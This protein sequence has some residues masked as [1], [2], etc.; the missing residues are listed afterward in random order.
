MARRKTTK[1]LTKAQRSFYIL[2]N[3]NTEVYLDTA[4]CL[5]AV[6]RKLFRQGYCYGIES[7][8]FDFTGADPSAVDQVQLTAKTAADDWVT[9][10]AFVKGHALFNEMN[11]L[12]LKDN[13]SI[14]SKWADYKVFLDSNHRSTYF[15]S[16]NAQPL[17][18][19]GVAYGMGEWNYSDYV[20]PQHTVNV[21]TGAPLPAD[22]T[23]AHLIGPD[24]G[25][26][27]AGNLQSVGLIQAY[28]DSRATVF[29]DAPN[30]P[31]GFADSFFNVLTDSGSQEP[32]LAGVIRAENDN[33]PYDLNNYPGGSTNAPV[34]VGADF[35]TA[36]IG[37][38]NAVVG[39]FVAPC[40][41][42]RLNLQS[43]FQGAQAASFPVLMRVT[44]MAGKYK[45]I[46]AI[47]MGQ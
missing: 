15:A 47:P 27:A 40:G 38:P 1:A 29:P 14:Q 33:P 3:T 45:G 6:N 20:L 31:A 43:Y 36:T 13:P 8:E 32:E 35:S 39:P 42:M 5:S 12:V 11:D 28:A 2:V 17:A 30:T 34:A 25:S 41:L 22:Q 44:L 37:A 18:D 23:N 9:N 16:G 21:G 10:N 26:I 7:I 46:A 19:V 4:E 24:V